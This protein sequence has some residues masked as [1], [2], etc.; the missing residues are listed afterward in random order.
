MED[1]SS[2]LKNPNESIKSEPKKVKTPRT[3]PPQN[4][5]NLRDSQVKSLP[6]KIHKTGG[7]GQ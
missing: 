2:I 3:F 4:K 5:F 1:G 6:H 7:R